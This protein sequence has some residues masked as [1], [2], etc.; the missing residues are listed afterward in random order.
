VRPWVNSSRRYISV[1]MFRRHA[2]GSRYNTA[3]R[4]FPKQKENLKSSC[5]YSF[6]SLL[7]PGARGFAGAQRRESNPARSLAQL[8]CQCIPRWSGSSHFGS[9]VVRCRVSSFWTLESSASIPDARRLRWTH[10]QP[11]PLLP[12]PPRSGRARNPRTCLT[13]GPF[14]APGAKFPV[15]SS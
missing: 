5:R 4:R 11:N 12:K 9:P 7:C 3:W 6:I 2:F 10:R 14:G 8:R 15:S 1:E 13:E